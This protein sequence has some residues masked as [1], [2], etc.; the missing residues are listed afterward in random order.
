MININVANQMPQRVKLYYLA[1]ILII[2]LVPCLFLLPYG[3]NYWLSAL[4]FLIIIIGLPIYI[5][6][7]VDYAFFKFIVDENKITV[8]SGMIIKH[9]KTI[10][11]DRIQNIESVRGLLSQLFGLAKIKIWTA[12]PSQIE[13]KK[14][15]SENKP[16]GVFILKTLDTEWFKNFVSDKRQKV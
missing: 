16:E 1:R 2:F 3:K 8:N 4:V 6:L 15:V 13:I 9:S 10:P 11:F 5:V 14:G 7:L 12:S